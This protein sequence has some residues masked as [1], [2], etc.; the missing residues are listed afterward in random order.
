MRVARCLPMHSLPPML[1]YTQ[2]VSTRIYSEP[3]ST[4]IAY[5]Q[6]VVVNPFGFLWI[7]YPTLGTKAICVPTKVFCLTRC[8]AWIHS[9][10]LSRT[11][12]IACKVCTPFRH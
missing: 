4:N 3:K 10:H 12:M 2:A 1:N 9:N 7:V 6:T 11:E 8:C 5:R